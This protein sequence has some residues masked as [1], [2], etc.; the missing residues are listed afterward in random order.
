MDTRDTQAVYAF[1]VKGGAN[2]TLLKRYL[3][4][5]GGGAN[6]LHARVG[7]AAD[8]DDGAELLDLIADESQENAP[9]TSRAEDC[10]DALPSALNRLTVSQRHVVVR[11]FGLD[12]TA[13]AS[14]AEIARDSRISATSAAQLRDRAFKNLR[15][16]LRDHALAA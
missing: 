10:A 16:L 12:G 11:A 2:P 5:L 6:S 13:P 1:G 8:T 15:P 3:H 4:L 9:G 14:L 7:G